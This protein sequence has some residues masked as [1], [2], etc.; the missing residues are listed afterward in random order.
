MQGRAG[1]AGAR[2]IEY[3]RGMLLPVKC[4]TNCQNTPL[5]PQDLS[6][7]GRGHKHQK[8]QAERP[9]GGSLYSEEDF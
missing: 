8:Q 1:L 9:T 4:Q 3:G 5:G 7:T 2:I 6:C